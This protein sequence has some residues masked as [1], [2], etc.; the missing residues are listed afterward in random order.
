[1]THAKWPPAVGKRGR[2]NEYDAAAVDEAV[3]GHFVREQPADE[4][5]EDLLTVAQIAEYARVSPSTVRSDLSR[6]RI[7]LGAPDDTTGGVKRWRRAKVA[8][9][10]AGRRRYNR[11]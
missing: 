9:A 8:A 11:S 3:R 10:Y 4:D 1:M 7:D 6:G 2:W 5:S